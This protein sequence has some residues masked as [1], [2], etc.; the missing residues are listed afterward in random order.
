MERK[1]VRVILIFVLLAILTFSFASTYDSWSNVKA[2]SGTTKPPPHKHNNVYNYVDA[3]SG[4]HHI[5]VNCTTCGASYQSRENHSYGGY[6]TT[7]NPT[8]T[9]YRI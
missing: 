9:S 8:C 6:R 2:A 3:G 1:N 5:F 7:T 4:R